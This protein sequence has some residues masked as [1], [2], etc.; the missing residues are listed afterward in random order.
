METPAGVGSFPGPE[1][2]LGDLVHRVGRTGPALPYAGPVTAPVQGS[3]VPAASGG[4]PAP[5]D[6]QPDGAAP[7]WR[8]PLLA[9]VAAAAG[10]L[11]IA[12]V[13]PQD[14]GVPICWSQGLFGVD[15]PLCGGLRATNALLRGDVAAAADHNVF[16]AVALP[17]VAV[18]WVAWVVAQVVGRPFRLPRVPRWLMGVGVVAAVAFTVAR[19]VGGPAW[20]DWLAATSYR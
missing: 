14:S 19:N 11:A 9:G 15:C 10:C 16:V 17:V 8:K 20:V 7:P 5:T 4:P 3:D 2:P 18:V 13:D 1:Q 12:V 6:H